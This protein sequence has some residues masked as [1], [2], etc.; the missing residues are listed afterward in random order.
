MYDSRCFTWRGTELYYGSRKILEVVPDD[1]WLKMWR[2][3]RPD[4]TLTDMVN[5]S[6]AKDAGL[7][8]ARAF[9]QDGETPKKTP[10]VR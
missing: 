6:R 1:R 10:P 5:L 9:L 3:R 7:S 8:I 2:V 4:G